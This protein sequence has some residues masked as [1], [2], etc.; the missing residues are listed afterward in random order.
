MSAEFDR[1]RKAALAEA[2]AAREEFLAVVRG[3]NDADLRVG[4]RGSWTVAGVIRHVIDA[5]WMH[6]RGIAHLRE[7]E[8][9]ERALAEE[10]EGSRRVEEALA[11]LGVSGERL[12]AAVDE[13]DEE[14][15][16]RLRKVGGQEWSVLGFLEGSADHDR[17][18]ASQIRALLGR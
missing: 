14:T 6:G 13:V 11:L 1:D 3:L 17:E 18:H 12:F 5:D 2:H 7:A 9:P 10:V 16:Y 15:F 4:R 8:A